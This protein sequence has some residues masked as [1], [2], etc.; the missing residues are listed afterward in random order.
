MKQ[1]IHVRCYNCGELMTIDVERE[2][3]VPPETDEFKLA[4]D[5]R[6]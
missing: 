2:C 6:D 3:V 5:E 1:I 4:D